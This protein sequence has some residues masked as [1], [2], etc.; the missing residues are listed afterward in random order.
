ME[1]EIKLI[2]KDSGQLKRKLLALGAVL[3]KNKHQVDIYYHHPSKVLHEIGQYLRVRIAGNKKT[4]AHHINL[5]DGVNDECE[6]GLEKDGEIE[7]LLERL[8]FSRAGTIDKTRE[9]Y[10]IGDFKVCL[11]KV[12]GI[13]DLVEIELEADSGK[14]KRAL[15][16]CWNFAQKLGF[17][18][19]DKFEFWLCDI[20][21]GKV[22]WPPK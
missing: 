7:K 3:E 15:N 11:D 12:K 2:C 20:A 21:V 17:S 18:E 4:L 5:A 19:K 9:Q 16:K 1:V 8:S 10:L 22:K 6:V 13:G 14:E